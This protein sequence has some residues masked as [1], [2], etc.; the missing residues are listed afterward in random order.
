MGVIKKLLLLG[1]GA[2]AGK[3]VLEKRRKS[4]L[5]SRGPNTDIAVVVD[6]PTGTDPN[7]K[8]TTAGFEDK[9]I[10]QAVNQD[11]ELAER[12]LAESDGD[13]AEAER[14]FMNESAGA[15]KLRAQEHD[16]ESG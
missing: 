1:V 6:T 4:Q 12:L 14:R 3:A 7:A 9:S 5:G 10:G 8:Y 2:A 11:A 15:P 13:K 16:S